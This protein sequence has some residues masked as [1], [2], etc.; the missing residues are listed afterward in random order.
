MSRIH[1]IL[2]TYSLCILEQSCKCIGPG[3]E[4]LVHT[5]HWYQFNEKYNGK[6]I[7]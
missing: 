3:Q 7:L 6:S 5:I 1:Y 2:L 4:N